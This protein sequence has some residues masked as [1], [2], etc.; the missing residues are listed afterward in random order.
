[1][2]RVCQK[3]IDTPSSCIIKNHVFTYLNRLKLHIISPKMKIQ[4]KTFGYV[5][6]MLYLCT[7]F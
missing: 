4:H 2:R 3:N 1:M 7:K 5:Q 6:I